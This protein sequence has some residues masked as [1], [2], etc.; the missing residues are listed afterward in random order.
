[1]RAIRRHHKE[2]MRAK[3]RRVARQSWNTP[4]KW[5]EH[6][7]VRHADNLKSCSCSMCCNVRRNEWEKGELTRQEAEAEQR[8]WESIWAD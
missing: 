3:A 4:E 8:L 6:Q 2:R 5:V 1:M 7:A